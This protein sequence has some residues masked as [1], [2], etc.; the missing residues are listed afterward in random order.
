LLVWWRKGDRCRV[1]P[2]AIYIGASFFTYLNRVGFGM[3]LQDEE[4]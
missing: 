4:G 1:D 2:N 3:C